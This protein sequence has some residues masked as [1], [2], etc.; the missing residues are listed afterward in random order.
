MPSCRGEV[1]LGH[2]D[3]DPNMWHSSHDLIVSTK[4]SVS[5]LRKLTFSIW[6]SIAKPTKSKFYYINNLCC[7]ISSLPSKLFRFFAS[8]KKDEIKWRPF[9]SVFRRLNLFLSSFLLS[10]NNFVT[11][12]FVRAGLIFYARLFQGNARKYLLSIS[13]SLASRNNV[14]D[15]FTFIPGRPLIAQI[16]RRREC[17][18]G[19]KKQKDFYILFRKAK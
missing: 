2:I 12:I 5:I 19:N 9:I 7:E 14:V 1:H 13:P 10:L 15:A 16:K 8:Q 3:S 4:F 17:W 18:S 6:N 11:Y